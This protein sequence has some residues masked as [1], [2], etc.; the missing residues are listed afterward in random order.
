MRACV[1]VRAR[2]GFSLIEL[3]AVIV[4]VG[5]L[6][7]VLIPVIGGARHSADRVECTSNL[8][9]IGLAVGSYATDH[10]GTLPGPAYS[11]VSVYYYID[12]GST[13]LMGYYLGPYL[14]MGKAPYSTNRALCAPLLCPA[15][16]NAVA[17]DQWLYAYQAV[18]ILPYVNVGQEVRVSAWGKA[19][20]TETNETPLK[21]STLYS[22]I[23]PSE[24]WAF[25]DKDVSLAGGGT[26]VAHGDYRNTLFF[27]WHVEAVPVD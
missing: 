6:S 4:V 8:R 25:K 20:S 21:I 9:Q 23:E 17:E 24:I 5:I 16:A 19:N 18:Y 10:D 1:A 2:P 7:A 15:Y 11:S 27:D 22:L 12:N 3:L 14:G 26:L 13:K